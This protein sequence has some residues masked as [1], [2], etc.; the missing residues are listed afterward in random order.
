MQN[1][2]MEEVIKAP[3]YV[4][5]KI[6]GMATFKGVVLQSKRFWAYARRNDKGQID[7]SWGKT[8][9]II[10]KFPWIAK[11]PVV[12]SAVF[13]FESLLNAVSRASSGKKVNQ[14]LFIGF[15]VGII[16]DLLFI[17]K[18]AVNIPRIYALSQLIPL[19]I[20]F[21]VMRL[22]N[23]ARYHGAEHKA[24]SAYEKTPRPT[25]EQIKEASRIHPRCGTNVALP[26]M[27][28]L[29]FAVWY[30]WGFMFQFLMIVGILEV[31]RY[32]S[33]NP[34]SII[35]KGYLLGGFALQ[36]VTTMEPEEDKIEVAAAALNMLLD[37]EE[38]F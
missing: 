33:K 34:L 16:I 13:F 12:R 10:S 22:T 30:S 5:E 7:L 31:F 8:F 19:P 1:R 4:P 25:I 29:S 24:V 2:V 3:Q 23:V 6:G 20:F 38:Q 36:R 9:S 11:I 15:T 28:G 32:I 18:T 27:V 37:L 21:V 35:S 26:L 17:S 14:I